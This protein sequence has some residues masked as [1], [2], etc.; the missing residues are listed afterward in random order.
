[1]KIDFDGRV[2]FS[3]GPATV[4]VDIVPRKQKS[5]SRIFSYQ[6]AKLRTYAI[7]ATTATTTLLS[8]PNECLAENTSIDEGQRTWARAS[9]GYKG[10][11]PRKNCAH[12]AEWLADWRTELAKRCTFNY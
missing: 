12:P 4:T 3:E 7:S 8:S 1:M 11:L 9:I 6:L 5:S 2:S 10:A